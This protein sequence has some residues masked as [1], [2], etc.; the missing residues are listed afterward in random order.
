MEMEE[1]YSGSDN[2][3]SRLGLLG[4]GAVDNKAT[5][6][7][8]EVENNQLK[9]QILNQIAIFEQYLKV[10]TLQH[11]ARQIADEEDAKRLG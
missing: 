11:K 8:M 7:D 6:Q 9:D 10:A 2:G 1:E 4:G 5:W 3:G